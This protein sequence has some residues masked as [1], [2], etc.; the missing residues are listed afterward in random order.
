MVEQ[1]TE[2]RI[3]VRQVTEVQ[4]SWSEEGRGEHGS[5]TV[6]L[7]LDNGAEEYVL[8]PT[9]EDAKVQLELFENAS[10]VYFDLDRKVLIPN[11][12]ALG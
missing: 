10:A 2:D 3:R 1:R 12:L 11:N 9:A 4:F 7:V 8:Q 6:Q 5:F